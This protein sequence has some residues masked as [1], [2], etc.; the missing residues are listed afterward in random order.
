MAKSLGGMHY[1]SRVRGKHEFRIREQHVADHLIPL[2]KARAIGAAKLDIVLRGVALL[3]EHAGNREVGL[4]LPAY[5]WEQLHDLARTSAG[6][7]P[8]PA[9]IAASAETVRLKRKW[10][11]EQ[12]ARLEELTLVE[13][14]MRPGRRPTLLVL[15]DSGSG[16]PLDD[17][18]GSPG[19]RYVRI[20]G[21]IIA[22]GTLA[23]WG[24]PK[25]AAFLAAMV[26]ERHADAERDRA[27]R[28]D[29][30][31]GRWYRP[32]G[33]FADREGVY[34]SQH[35]VCLPFAEKTLERGFLELEAD[36]LISRTRSSI[37]PTTNRRFKGPRIIYQNKFHT[38]NEEAGVMGREEYLK[39]LEQDAADRD[40]A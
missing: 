19:N 38:L 34:D 16:A 22:T 13:R 7:G 8:R 37:N 29:P 2:M 18:D 26:A 28:R 1:G 32:L 5:S 36:G 33:W 6:L 9:D 39:Q 20:P 27:E 15:S 40:A 17:P 14:T 30:G 35:R 4:V 10:V 11:G 31:S 24:T 25:L 21:A 23:G 12:L 3:E